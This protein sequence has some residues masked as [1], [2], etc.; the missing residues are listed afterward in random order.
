MRI[1]HGATVAVQRAMRHSVPMA[2]SFI[3]TLE[4]RGPACAI[5]LTDDQVA[6][7]GGGKRAAVWVSIGDRTAALRVAVMGGENMIGLSKAARADLAVMIGDQVSVTIEVRETPSEV[8]VPAEL[9]QALASDKV[10]A[11]AYRSL[12]YTHRKEFAAWVAQ[13]K[14]AQTR[15]RRAS[16][17]VQMLHEGRT[18]S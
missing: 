16:Q 5:L 7:L 9:A 12:A 2:L 13:A 1:L 11:E 18:R 8:D 6:Q 10:A 3:T 4:P 17:S 14:Q 15:L